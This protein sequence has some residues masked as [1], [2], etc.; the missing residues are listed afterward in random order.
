MGDDRLDAGAGNDVVWGGVA[1]FGAENFD[2]STDAARAANFTSPPQ[3]DE[4]EA[5]PVTAT[6]YAPP[7]LV[8]PRI[9]A[10]S[11]L[12][13]RADDGHDLLM[14]GVGLDVLFGG[15]Q[16]DVLLGG[17]NEDYL[18][19]GSGND[20][21][22]DGGDG[23]DVVRGGANNDVV[24]GNSG[25]DQVFGD[26][27]DDVVYGDVGILENQ[28]GQRLFGGDGDDTLYA[29]AGD[30][31]TETTQIGDQLSGDDGGDFLYGNQRQELLVGGGGN[32]LLAGDALAGSL[33][34][35]SPNADT[36]GG[37][38][39]LIGGVGEDQLVGGGGND[40]LWGG[41]STDLLEG[42]QGND[43]AYGGSGIDLFVLFIAA[44]E[45][46]M[47]RTVTAATLPA[48]HNRPKTTT[49]PI[50]WSSMARHK[51]IRSCSRKPRTVCPACA[52]ITAVW[53]RRC[54]SIGLTPRRVA[55]WSNRFSSQASPATT[56]WDSPRPIRCPGWNRS[57]CWTP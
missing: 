22:I 6:G 2:A 7:L 54:L 50:S 29:F 10:G 56:D 28:H 52:S 39:L 20:L 36:V 4:L 55:L 31:A 45:N 1:E 37:D 5:D 23:D 27:G 51:T 8:T 43:L 32:D 18:D 48:R 11:S 24:H 42:Q 53:Q 57:R 49:R 38:D 15:S 41:A 14:G 9:V 16:R 19:A 25:I 17:D 30:S 33:Y 26:A 47:L 13:G 44:G 3:F 46:D 34:R 21:E 40:Q 35:F 12:P